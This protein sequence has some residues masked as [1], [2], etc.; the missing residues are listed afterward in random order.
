M[1]QQALTTVVGFVG[2]EPKRVSAD[3]TIPICR[4]RVAAT[5]NYWNRRENRWQETSTTWMDVRCYRNLALNVMASLH[6]GDPV[7]VLGNLTTDRW[8]KDGAKRSITVIDASSIGHD[9]SQGKAAFIRI[10]H[11]DDD[12][13]HE[14]APSHTD[15]PILGAEADPRDLSSG[16]IPGVSAGQEEEFQVGEELED[17]MVPN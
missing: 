15:D 11:T 6:V 10:R 5:R 7:I 3:N 12:S 13:A 8:E 2:Q 16:P 9:L 4:F 14:Q 1:V 17:D